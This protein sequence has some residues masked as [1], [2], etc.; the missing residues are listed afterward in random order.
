VASRRAARCSAKYEAWLRYTLGQ[1]VRACETLPQRPEPV[2]RL[3]ADLRVGDA[4]VRDVW[5]ALRMLY[6]WAHV[7]LGCRDAMGG[8]RRPLVRPKVPRTLTELEVDQLLWANRRRV[9]DYALLDTGARIGEASGLG[10]RD[11]SIDGDGPT[12]RL[13]G[14]TG[15]R[16]V[17]VGDETA[18]ALRQLDGD[19]LWRSERSGEPLTVGGLQKAVQRA[20]RRAG[21]VGG[22]HLLRHTFGKLYV[23]RGGDLVSLQRLMGHASVSTTRLYLEL[24]LRDVRRQH[25]KFSP[26]AGRPAEEQLRLHAVDG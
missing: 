16:L 14:K 12:L 25:A 4:T 5:S 9:R 22:P 26:L 18:R 17:P 1:L 21:L 6:R 13:W 15:E 8:V 24:D 2:E 11:L 20:V 3:L 23:L 7:R 10:W 19:E